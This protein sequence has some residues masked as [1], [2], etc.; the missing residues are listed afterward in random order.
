MKNIKLLA[1]Y[2]KLK[3]GNSFLNKTIKKGTTEL[4]FREKEH[5]LSY[6]TIKKS[7]DRRESGGDICK[8]Y[9]RKYLIIT[10]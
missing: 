5:I 6:Y 8:I 10:I 9:L 2:L 7:K 1:S 3:V 4:Y